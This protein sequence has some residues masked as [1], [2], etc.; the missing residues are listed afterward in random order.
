MRILREEG[1]VKLV[2]GVTGNILDDDVIEYLS[3]GVD[4]VMGKP[5]KLVSLKKL[6]EY[7]NNEH[8]NA[9]RPGMFLSEEEISG[10][11][12]WKRK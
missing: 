7:V 3:D 6:L 12:T 5:L 11:L 4:M 2:V 8:G 9:S 10:L 1:Y